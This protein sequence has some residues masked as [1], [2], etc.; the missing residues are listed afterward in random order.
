MSRQSDWISATKSEPCG[1]CGR[2]HYCTRSPDGEMVWC[3]L[4]KSDWPRKDGWLHRLKDTPIP[5]RP[6][7]P[8]RKTPTDH[9]YQAKWEPWAKHC[10]RNSEAQVRRLAAK[11]GVAY[12]ALDALGVG[13]TGTYWTFPEKNHRGQIVGINRRYLSG[14]QFAVSGGKRALTYCEDWDAYPAPMFVVEGGSDVA[15]GLTLGLCVVGRPS[16]IGGVDYLVKLL[17]PFPA[18][19]IVVLGE[20]DRKRHE[21]LKP[22]AKERHNPKCRCCLQCYPGRAGALHVRAKLKERL[23]RRKIQ[24]RMP[25]DGAKDLRSWLNSRKVDVEDQDAAFALGRKVFGG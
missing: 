21:D 22:L 9:E 10:Y 15:A 2:D 5:T 11:L 20:R 19:R 1:V 3:S 16:N 14:K 4:E 12:W 7:R 24:W 13:Y 25:P 23:L 17:G 8:K 18:S 6:P